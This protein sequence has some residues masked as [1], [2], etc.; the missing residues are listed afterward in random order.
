MTNLTPSS[1]VKIVL[2]TLLCLV[3]CAG[4]GGCMLGVQSSV[5]TA[6]G[7]FDSHYRSADGSE[8]QNV[9]EATVPAES[10]RDLEIGWLA[11]SV[12]VRPIDDDLTDGSVHVQEFVRD[13]S[14]DIPERNKMG[15]S[16]NGERLSVA[17]G[18]GRFFNWGGLTSCAPGSEKKLVITMPASCAQ[19]LRSVEISGASG[20]YVLAGLSCERLS[21]DLA[22]GS[23]NIERGVRANELNLNMASGQANIEGVFPGSINEDRASGTSFIVCHDVCP[24]LVNISLASG[25][26]QLYVPEGSGYTI[27]CDK[28]S[29][30]FDCPGATWWGAK[31]QYVA[32]DGSAT[33]LV[34]M[35][36]GKV[37]I[38]QGADLVA[39]DAAE[40]SVSAAPSAPE[41]PQAPEAPAAPAAPSVS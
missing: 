17:Y 41:A 2:I 37:V 31:D 10:V 38:G 9:G 39:D 11:G 23:L 14:T 5:R 3:L 21:I 28:L 26:T 35:M 22:S 1:W 12:E 8:F 15:W 27:S 16:L 7:L 18:N 30:S 36:S 40:S 6:L 33:F 32:G 4:V 19:N 13:D 29:G 20:R 34:D 24:S 25:S